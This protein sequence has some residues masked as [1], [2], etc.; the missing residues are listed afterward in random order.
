MAID[1]NRKRKS[2]MTRG[3]PFGGI[4]FPSGS[5]D[6]AARRHMCF[7]YAGLVADAALGA[8]KNFQ[9]FIRNVSRLGKH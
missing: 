5:I 8:P 4:P 3:V 2:A 7:R 6:E 9:G 1:T